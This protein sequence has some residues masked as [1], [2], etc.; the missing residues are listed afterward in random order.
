M[1]SIIELAD[2]GADKSDLSDA[3]GRQGMRSILK[4]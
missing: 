1:I 2:G 4:A 3:A